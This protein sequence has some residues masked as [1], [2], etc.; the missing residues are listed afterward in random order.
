M[1]AW[2]AKTGRAT[3][4]R[5]GI[6]GVRESM[7]MRLRPCVTGTQSPGVPPSRGVTLTN[8]RHFVLGAFETGF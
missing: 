1:P 3:Y 2:S 5:P 6:E 7:V 8:A 4:I